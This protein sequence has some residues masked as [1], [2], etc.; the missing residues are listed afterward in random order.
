M[1]CPQVYHS[2]CPYHGCDWDTGEAWFLLAAAHCKTMEVARLTTSRHIPFAPQLVI[3]L[4]E[5]LDLGLNLFAVKLAGT[6]MRM[7]RT[8]EPLDNVSD[9]EEGDELLTIVE[10]LCLYIQNS[11]LAVT[12]ELNTLYVACM[13][14]LRN[15][16]LTSESMSR[17]TSRIPCKLW[18]QYFPCCQWSLARSS[19]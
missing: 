8:F 18:F 2:H 17:W 13:S 19:L 1:S 16:S 12:F 5:F 4:A 11:L 14:L 7:Q 6:C 15:L 3:L 10:S 9:L